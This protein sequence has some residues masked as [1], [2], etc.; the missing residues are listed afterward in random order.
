MA[1]ATDIAWAAGLFDGEG[2][3]KAH[4]RANGYTAITMAVAMTDEE[5]VARFAEIVGENDYSEI[6]RT[7]KTGKRVFRWSVCSDEKVRRVLDLLD[8]YLGSAK[9]EDGRIARAQR[10]EAKS[11]LTYGRKVAA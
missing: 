6:T 2:S 1:T 8:P 3:I 4:T 7:T 5:S 10:A 9:R 11:Q